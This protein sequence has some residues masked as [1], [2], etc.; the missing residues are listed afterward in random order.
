V[1]ALKIIAVALIIAGGSGLS[2]GRARDTRETA[3]APPDFIAALVCGSSMVDTPVW[4][5]LAALA[6]GALLLLTPKE[7]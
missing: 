7:P 4:A 1:N 5:G 6:A 2:Y 3:Q